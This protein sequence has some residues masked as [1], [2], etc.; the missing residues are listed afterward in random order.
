MIRALEL[1]YSLK[2]INDVGELTLPLG[3]QLAEFPVDPM[4]GKILLASGE[5]KCSEE[6]VTIAAMLSVQDIWVQ[7]RLPKEL[8][9]EA[10]RK[11]WVE[12]G[13][14][15]SLLNVYNAFVN[16]GNKSGK[17]CHDRLLNFGECHP[18]VSCK[19]PG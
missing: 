10:R 4:L 18:S 13:D 8:V 17:W 12:D 19:R 9:M 1:L 6:I 3:E 16:K 5:F 7:S 14:H 15:L 2:A 11:F